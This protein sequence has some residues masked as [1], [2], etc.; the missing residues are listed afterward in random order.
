[1][2]TGEGGLIV[3]W[4]VL[5]SGGQGKPE[6]F[7]G[8]PLDVSLFEF[9]AQI[10]KD[11]E[12]LSGAFDII[13]GAKPTGVE[14]FS[15]L[16]LLVERSQSRF[17]SVF[18]ARGEMYRNWFSVA[19]ELERQ[20]GPQ[21]RTWAVVGPS[22]GYT[23]QHFQNAQLQGQVRIS[24]EDGTNMPKTA[25]G[26]RAAIEQANQLGLLD[27]NDPDQKQT[28]LTV[29]GISDIIPSLNIHVHAAN[30]LQDL[31]EKWVQN[32]QGPSPLVLKPWFDPHIHWI[33]R[34]KWLNTDKMREMMTANPQIEQIIT[35]HLQELQF[36]LNPPVQ[37][38]PDG[39]PIE[40]PA[41]GPPTGAN[42]PG[43]GQAMTGSNK[44]S[45]AT[46]SLPKGNNQAGAQ[47][48]GPR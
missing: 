16:Q 31:F 5:A 14:A 11:M 38:G 6:R 39:K 15:A 46:S 2:L 30:E 20:F 7:P 47:N 19:L 23:F 40:Q 12:E 43:G 22:S 44:N 21:E 33:E 26:K 27:A 37:L 42:A 35:L 13:K 41:G 4:N 25:L 17:T 34:I 10:I 36:V 3:R 1:M 45:A 24:I 18:Q 29:F 8:I 32:P 9:R 28:L 48:Q